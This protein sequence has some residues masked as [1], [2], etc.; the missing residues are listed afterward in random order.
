MAWQA[1]VRLEHESVYR[2][3]LHDAL[4]VLG[5]ASCSPLQKAAQTASVRGILMPWRCAACSI[6]V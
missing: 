4:L 6:L 2:Q 5:P 3:A 1:P